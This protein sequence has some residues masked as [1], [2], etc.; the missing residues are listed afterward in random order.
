MRLA[1][2]ILTAAALASGCAAPDLDPSVKHACISAADAPEFSSACLVS[3]KFSEEAVE[4]G[5][6]RRVPPLIAY[7]SSAP[8]RVSLHFD[9]AGIRVWDVLWS[10]DE[11]QEKRHRL[12]SPKVSLEGFM[13][14]F[15]LSTWSAESL[16]RIYGDDFIE[17]KTEH[18]FT[19]TLLRN[20]KAFI[21]I[22]SKGREVLL[23][24]HHEGY[25]L[26]IVQ[27]DY[28]SSSM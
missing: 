18:G 8:G 9:A 23:S 4:R 16:R 28:R 7:A 3:I 10:E 24:N 26:R 19:R 2:I 15:S 25:Q 21:R 17:A 13:R 11:V 5:A 20:G 22:E 6:P 1:G 14:D 12:L 27:A